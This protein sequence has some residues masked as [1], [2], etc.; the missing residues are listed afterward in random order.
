MESWEI[1]F[2]WLEVRHKLAKSLGKEQ[3]P[4]LQTTLFLIGIQ[5]L[6]WWQEKKFSKE[7]KQDLMHVGLCTLLESDGYYEFIGRDQ[8]GWPHWKEIK[9]YDIKG[10]QLQE[11]YLIT[12]I[13]EYFSNVF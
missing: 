1:E 2:K 10:I 3:I 7:E 6:G 11:E 5:E 9:P 8:D 12:K 13:V 4:D